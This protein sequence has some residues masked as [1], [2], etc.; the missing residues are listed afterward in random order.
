MARIAPADVK[1]I[2]KVVADR[3]PPEM[4]FLEI[5]RDLIPGLARVAVLASTPATDPFS[6]PFVDD[7]QAAA[8]RAGL[9]LEPVMI[10]G[11]GDFESAFAAMARAGAQAVIVQG[12][13]DPHRKALLELA[14]KH[15]LAYMSGNRETTVAGGLVSISATFLG[16][17]AISSFSRDISWLTL[18][19]S[20][21][22]SSSGFIGRTSWGYSDC[23]TLAGSGASW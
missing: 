18:S 11:P 12:L 1:A 15:R 19:N 2:G 10:N 8:T 16:K 23:S 5:L 9:Q 14:A 21:S 17:P 4:A 3:I 13:F 22:F 6:R 7:L 20:I